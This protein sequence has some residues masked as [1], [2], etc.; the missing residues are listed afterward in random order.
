MT[1]FLNN[2]KQSLNVSYRK[3]NPRL[4]RRMLQSQRVTASVLY[5]S[6]WNTFG[7][8]PLWLSLPTAEEY[9]QGSGRRKEICNGL[10]RH[11]DDLP[12]RQ[13]IDKS[14]TAIPPC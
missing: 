14:L 13:P 1:K 2:L 8:N 9:W 10:L 11:S 7:E 12:L 5:R 4:V 3:Q 6:R